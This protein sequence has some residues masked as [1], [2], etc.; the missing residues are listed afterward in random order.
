M[1]EAITEVAKKN[2]SPPEVNITGYV[3]L[4]SYASNGVEVIRKALGSINGDEIF[5]TVCW[6]S[7]IQ[8]NG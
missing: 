2:I 5:R 3:D 1:G 8:N 4:K 6:C 7:K